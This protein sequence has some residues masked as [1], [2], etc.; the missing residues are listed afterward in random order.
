VE[1]FLSLLLGEIP[2]LRD[3]ENGY[4]PNGKR[5]IGHVEIPDDVLA[6]YERLLP[7]YGH[8]ERG[9]GTLL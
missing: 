1:R 7:R 6:A 9:T 8:A 4:G 5:F 3:D 2:R